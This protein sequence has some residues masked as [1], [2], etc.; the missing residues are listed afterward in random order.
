MNHLKFGALG[1]NP[2]LR[3]FISAICFH[4]IYAYALS[5][6]GFVFAAS[7]EKGLSGIANRGSHILTIAQRGKKGSLEF[8]LEVQCF[9]SI[10][11]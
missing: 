8:T 1:R 11:A 5:K 7:F 2:H 4:C 3:H 6:K 10:Q 9:E